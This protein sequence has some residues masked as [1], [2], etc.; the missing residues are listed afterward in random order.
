MAELISQL[1]SSNPST[2]G[3]ETLL[4]NKLVPVH[5]MEVTHAYVMGNRVID[6]DQREVD[7]LCQKIIRWNTQNT[8]IHPL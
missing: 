5:L 1:N 8:P 7:E 2:V 6:V 4:L 3:L